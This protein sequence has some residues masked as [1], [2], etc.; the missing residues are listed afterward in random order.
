M[1]YCSGVITPESCWKWFRNRKSC[2]SGGNRRNILQLILEIDSAVS[3]LL[4]TQFS[5]RYKDFHFFAFFLWH[6][7][8]FGI[9]LY[10][11][12]S[13]IPPRNPRIFGIF[14][15][16]ELQN[17]N[18]GPKVSLEAFKFFFRFFSKHSVPEN[19]IVRF[20]VPWNQKESR[21][22]SK[23]QLTRLKKSKE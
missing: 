1:T 18:P 19:D 16:S 2:F 10:H 22:R 11:S 7:K 15:N 23:N 14:T 12:Y 9:Q 21:F 3:S 6:Q 17:K 13:L 20:I 5:S 8:F 4:K